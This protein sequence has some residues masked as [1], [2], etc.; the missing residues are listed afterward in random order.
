MCV[1]MH[2]VSV[3]QTNCKAQNQAGGSANGGSQLVLEVLKKSGPTLAAQIDRLPT[4][5]NSLE[6]EPRVDRPPLGRWGG[7]CVVSFAAVITYRAVSL[8]SCLAWT[9]AVLAGGSD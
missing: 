7:G 9:S 1:Y 3:K 8:G 2:R 6:D 5:R 4:R